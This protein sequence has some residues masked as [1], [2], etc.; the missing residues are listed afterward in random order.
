VAQVRRDLQ[1]GREPATD[2]LAVHEQVS[3]A[4]VG[5]QP[6]EAVARLLVGRERH[7]PPAHEAAV[8]LRGR[9]AV[10]LDGPVGRHGLGRVDADV[11]QPL[12]AAVEPHED[13]VPVHDAQDT[14]AAE[15]AFRAAAAPE[16]LQAQRAAAGQ[17]GGGD[18][19]EGDQQPAHVR[20]AT[21]WAGRHAPVVALP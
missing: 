21:P 11:P 14:G 7:G 12:A 18:D 6:A 2:E 3:D 16:V 1:R 15:V 13:R 5:Q 9:A 19:D 8:L 20:D 17:E 4:H 10:A